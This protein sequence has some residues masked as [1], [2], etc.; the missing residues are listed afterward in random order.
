MFAGSAQEGFSHCNR[1]HGGRTCF[2]V[3]QLVKK[4][5]RTSWKQSFC[6][7]DGNTPPKPKCAKDTFANTD[8]ALTREKGIEA[9]SARAFGNR[10]NPFSSP[11]FPYGGAQGGRLEAGQAEIPAIHGL[12]F[13]SQRNEHS[14]YIQSCEHLGC[15][16]WP[17]KVRQTRSP[18]FLP[19]TGQRHKKNG[20]R[21]CKDARR[22]GRSCFRERLCSPVRQSFEVKP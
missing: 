6:N 7:G 10:I 16:R 1:G 13:L 3:R 15:Q 22:K 18:S 5:I 9:V 19:W 14:P 12:L 11:S 20:N 8:Y 21:F 17:R 2:P 4:T